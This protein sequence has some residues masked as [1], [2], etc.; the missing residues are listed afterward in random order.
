MMAT[1]KTL[2]KTESGRVDYDAVKLAWDRILFDDAP[3]HP[4][5]FRGSGRRNKELPLFDWSSEP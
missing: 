2:A 1:D 4:D 5:N 3:K